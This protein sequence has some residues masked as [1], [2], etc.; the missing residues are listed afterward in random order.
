MV[1]KNTRYHFK[2]EFKISEY[3]PDEVPDN[4][5]GDFD[6]VIYF[7]KKT[8]SNK[9]PFIKKPVMKT[10]SVEID[11]GILLYRD[12]FRIRPYGEID[13]IGF[14]WLGIEK[15]R[16]KNPAGVGRSGYMMQAN[17]LSGYVNITKEKNGGF[18]DQANREGL[19]NSDEFE[20]LETV[21]LRII[22]DFSS[23]RSEIII[24]YNE[25]L[26]EKAEVSYFS[27]EGKKTKK[28]LDRLVNKHQGNLQ[29]LYSDPE[30]KKLVS[31][32]QSLFEMYSL[33]DTTEEENTS[34]VSESDTLRTMATQGIVMSTFAH[35]IKN[36][37]MFFKEIP[38]N[39]KDTGD[40][41][42]E[43]FKADFH[44]IEK[45]YNL[46]DFSEAIERKTTSILGFLESS[47]NNP[48][49]DKK[50]EISLATYLFKIYSW[51]DN[52]IKDNYYSYSYLVNGKSSLEDLSEEIKNLYVYASETQLDSIFL[53]LITNSYKNFKSP[54]KIKNRIINVILD[55][56]DDE[57]ISITYED[58]GNGLDEKIKN[59]NTIFEPYKSY[60]KGGT[61]MGMAI[62]AS[63]VTNLKGETE[64]LS[65]PGEKGFKIR[66]GLKG[67]IEKNV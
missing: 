38:E 63:V 61:G 19:K 14:D 65:K 11:P 47:V 25:F 16:T 41:Y 30:Y 8:G 64:L 45:P 36:D 57:I 40:Y 20:Y 24:L 15:E 3:I 37:K 51:W 10:N 22:K 39:L 54:N 58:N 35:Q 13:T 6:G 12:G 43:R 7:A 46:Y 27:D 59:S 18:E 67:G 1:K 33:Q 31:N 32:P 28:K 44:T 42:S 23:I 52:S 4:S 29:E 17:Q 48:T 49:R 56:I 26:K 66:I 53:N 2:R 50:E 62:L 60:T 55:A 9:Y 34:L 5:I 21:I